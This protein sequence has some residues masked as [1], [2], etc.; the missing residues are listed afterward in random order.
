MK[1]HGLS[2]YK[3]IENLN[4]ESFYEDRFF[5]LDMEYIGA[6]E[7]VD[8]DATYGVLYGKNIKI[9][10][11]ETDDVWAKFKSSNKEFWQYVQLA[12]NEITIPHYKQIITKDVEW[13][14]NSANVVIL[15][16]F[17]NRGITVEIVSPDCTNTYTLFDYKLTITLTGSGS[18]KP[19]QILVKFE[20]DCLFLDSAGFARR[21]GDF[22]KWKKENEDRTCWMIGNDTNNGPQIV[23]S[24][25]VENKVSNLNA[26]D[27]TST[28][29]LNNQDTVSYSYEQ[30][31]DTE[32][33]RLSKEPKL[34]IYN[35]PTYAC[36]HK[37]V[38]S[39]IFDM[40]E[41]EGLLYL[42]EGNSNGYNSHIF[43]LPKNSTAYVFKRDIDEYELNVANKLTFAYGN[44]NSDEYNPTI[45]YYGANMLSETLNGTLKEYLPR[46]PYAEYYGHKEKLINPKIYDIPISRIIKGG[47][48]NDLNPDGGSP[49]TELTNANGSCIIGEFTTAKYVSYPQS[50]A[51]KYS[52]KEPD[53]YVLEVNLT[54]IG[55]KYQEIKTKKG[56]SKASPSVF[57]FIKEQVIEKQTDISSANKYIRTE[58]EG[59]P[60]D[61]YAGYRMNIAEEP[62]TGEDKNYT[63]PT[64]TDSKY[65]F[66]DHDAY[67]DTVR[68]F[69]RLPMQ[70][71][72]KIQYPY[73]FTETTFP[74]IDSVV[75]ETKGG[76]VNSTT[77]Y[78]SFVLHLKTD[79]QF[80][81]SKK[82]IFAHSPDIYDNNISVY[83]Y[84]DVAKYNKDVEYNYRSIT[85]DL[86][87]EQRYESYIA[88]YCDVQ[89]SGVNTQ[90]NDAWIVLKLA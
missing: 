80:N 83:I 50:Q 25:Y 61:S 16:P 6:D 46:F 60:K 4:T 15:H 89:H 66:V 36:L 53:P 18:K 13:I 69:R 37:M 30:D 45:P 87:T 1:V 27:T 34:N 86:K 32:Q 2:F 19:P 76:S 58:I 8:W 55:M 57:P 47:S 20:A 21:G 41:E 48:I 26:F 44:Y 10:C 74:C 67:S 31:K 70:C 35:A 43:A 82:A 49:G 3:D 33:Y 54:Q 63:K 9:S 23:G 84:K 28:Y 88:T 56:W 11:Y 73:C 65:M 40:R 51:Y 38:S 22:F 81:S 52:W 7:I 64:G 42:V 78:S 68:W 90:F 5:P 17:K 79:L 77:L 12:N 85:Y 59:R 75:L 29:R 72:M 39:N 71:K 24:V 62:L 14:G